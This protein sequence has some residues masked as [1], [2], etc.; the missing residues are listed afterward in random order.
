[1]IYTVTAKLTDNYFLEVEANSF[2]EALDI[3]EVTPTEN[4]INSDTNWEIDYEA[5]PDVSAE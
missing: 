4:W 1:M 3:A 2:A 5:D